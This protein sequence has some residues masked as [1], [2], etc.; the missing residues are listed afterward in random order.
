METALFSNRIVPVGVFQRLRKS[1]HDRATCPV[2]G[3]E[4]FLSAAASVVKT[5]SFNHL[6]RGDEEEERCPLSYS[7]HPSYSWLKNV[8]LEIVQ[9]RADRLKSQFYEPENLKRA[10]TFLTTLTGKGALNSSVFALLLRKLDQFDIWKYASLPVWAVPYIMLTF[11]DFVV[12]RSSKPAYVVRFIIDKPARSKLNTTWLHPGQ[13]SLA[14]YFVN[15]GKA[16]KLFGAGKSQVRPAP[17]P[18]S[19]FAAIPNPLPFR[20]QEFLRLTADTSWISNGLKNLIEEMAMVASVEVASSAHSASPATFSSNEAA[21][22]REKSLPVSQHMAPTSSVDKVSSQAPGNEAN[23]RGGLAWSKGEDATNSSGESQRVAKSDVVGRSEKSETAA[24]RLPVKS[25][26]GPANARVADMG[27]LAP[28]SHVS[29]VK[30]VQ[31]PAASAIERT[32]AIPSASRSASTAHAVKRHKAKTSKGRF[33]LWLG[34][35]FT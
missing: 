24:P 31:A 15:G 13:C 9:L 3:E 29:Q 27:P 14:K 2:C 16:T 20:E 4:V 26:V 10:F 7:Y 5:A 28:H 32:E 6:A 19:T 8:D 25:P 11:T 1:L 34:R 12:R 35:L 23:A 17:I 30:G 33:W 21:R 22:K 18:A